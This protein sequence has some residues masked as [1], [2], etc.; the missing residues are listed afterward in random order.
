[1]NEFSG[2]VRHLMPKSGCFLA[3]KDGA[4]EHQR[5]PGS[6]K[7][8]GIGHPLQMCYTVPPVDAV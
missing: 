3:G 8:F 2:V 7:L 1:M 5:M 4:V 6:L